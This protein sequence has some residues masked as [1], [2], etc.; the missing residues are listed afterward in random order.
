MLIY[1]KMSESGGNIATAIGYESMLENLKETAMGRIGGDKLAKANE[2][3][4]Q[5]TQANMLLNHYDFYK[6]L[7]SALN[8][9]VEGVAKS[10][11]AKIGE[12]LGM[13]D[14]E[15]GGVMEKLTN[16][17][18]SVEEKVGNLT[19]LQTKAQ[20]F[21][22]D[23]QQ[24]LTQAVLDN[25]GVKAEDGTELT[26]FIGNQV[27]SFKAQ[28]E[29]FGDFL[30]ASNPIKQRLDE[31][32]KAR[33][34]LEKSFNERRGQL[35]E[36]KTA[37]EHRYDDFTNDFVDREG[38]LPNI[39]EIAPF[40]READA[41][42]QEADNT[43]KQYLQDDGDLVNEINDNQGRLEE[44]GKGI[45]SGIDGYNP[46][47]GIFANLG[48]LDKPTLSTLFNPEQL[49]RFEGL[50]PY[51][52]QFTDQSFIEK[53][54]QLVQSPVR[55]LSADVAGNVS[56]AFSENADK[57]IQGATQQATEEFNAV[58][59]GVKQTY[60]N[61]KAQVE[62]QIDRA[63]QK[64]QEGVE[65][66]NQARTDGTQMLNDGKQAINDAVSSFTQGAEE[67]T[68]FAQKGEQLAQ[69]VQSGTKAL[70]ET[71]GGDTGTALAEGGEAVAS[72]IPV[73]GEVIDAGL[74][75]SSLITGIADI[76]KGRAHTTPQVVQ[77]TEQYGM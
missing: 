71:I 18:A 11:K 39:E 3:L 2:V 56:K 8:D 32:Q 76:F 26:E 47:E 5:L 52:G 20:A 12:K 40:Q 38:R 44:I 61:A 10:V 19:D 46:A 43:K 28:A 23:P 31:L 34:D 55:E 14:A 77:A 1:K 36:Q 58:R 7:A 42:K 17:K 50:S 29:G 73:V 59:S 72:V 60:N 68:S 30:N 66:F 37:L 57:A 16:L 49:T 53:A 51:L 4:T 9:K 74:I 65:A 45:F 22:K 15:E 62:Q 70:A 21:I 25:L 6:K 67:G 48:N 24:A 35:L 63:T 75:I 33:G 64:Y 27:N 69:G 41:F 13:G 54:S